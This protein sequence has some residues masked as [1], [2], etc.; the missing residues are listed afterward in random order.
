MRRTIVAI[1]ERRCTGCGLCM[2]DC[3]SGSLEVTDG[4]SRLVDD[5]CCDGCGACAGACPK[6]AI[7]IV[8]REARPFDRVRLMER[9]ASRGRGAVKEYLDYLHAR[10]ETALLRQAI[11]YLEENGIPVPAHRGGDDWAETAGRDPGGTPD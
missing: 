5:R 9:I 7:G 8:E 10:G 2:P 6:E 4:T 11:D 3:S 1:D